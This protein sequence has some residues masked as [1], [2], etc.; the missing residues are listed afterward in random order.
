MTKTIKTQSNEEAERIV[1]CSCLLPDGAETFD[2][3]SQ[4]VRQNDFHDEKNSCLYGAIQAVSDK[5]DEINELN[6]SEHLRKKDRLDYIGG[7]PFIYGIM[8]ACATS[9]QAISAAKIVRERSDARSL[10]RSSKLAIERI[11]RGADA[12][13]AKSFIESEINKINGVDSEDV[14]LGNVGSSFVDRLEQME[15]GTYKPEN[16]KTG[17]DHLDRK[18]NEGGIGKGEV[19]VI[20]APTSCGKSQL[21]LNIALRSAIRD[22]KG[23]AIFSLEM[24]SEQIYK[25][26]TQI[27]ACAN[28]EEANQ[29]DDKKKAFAPIRPATKKIAESPVYVYN[30][31]R[32]I[33]D[34]RSKCRNLKRKHNISMI[35]IDYLQLIPWNSK[36]QKCDG[37]AEV[38]HSIKQMAMELDVPVILLAQVNREGAKRG[39]L[40]V[41]DLKDSGDV[42]NDADI[43]LMM[44]PSNYDIAKSRRIDKSGKPYIELTYSLVKNREGERDELG[45][46]IFDNSTG[47]I[48]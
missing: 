37:V 28:I 42:E 5:G 19:M 15:N 36:L 27:S 41:F 30:T 26:M 29:S 25:R 10:L 6:I 21:A 45:T 24:P 18:L 33:S 46:F 8:D 35:V 43:I 20:S 47:R 13:D 11:E 12:Q 17:I 3:V 31:V 39:K 22:K 16:I 34:L 32:D 7:M 2:L 40:S 44:Y 48:F 14:S 4:V 1:L 38:S 23:V 9:L